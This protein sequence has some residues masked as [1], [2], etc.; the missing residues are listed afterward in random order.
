MDARPGNTVMSRYA[1]SVLV[2]VVAAASALALVLLAL[3]AGPASATAAGTK[4]DPT[5]LPISIPGSFQASNVG[6]EPSTAHDLVSFH[7]KFW[8]FT[9]AQSEQLS[10]CTLATAQGYDD[11]TLEVWSG[12]GAAVEVS[13]NDD[14]FQLYGSPLIE[15]S[16]LTFDTT[17]GTRYVVG[18]GGYQ[19]H[20]G[21]AKLVFAQGSGTNAC[22]PTPSITGKIY[23]ANHSELSAEDASAIVVT[24]QKDSDGSPS[25]I[26][27]NGDGTYTLRGLATGTYSLSFESPTLDGTLENIDVVDG[28]LTSGND[29]EVAP[30]GSISGTIHLPAGDD[31]SQAALNVWAAGNGEFHSGVLT[32]GVGGVAQYTISGLSASTFTV[33]VADDNHIYAQT[34]LPNVVV[35][36][37]QA[38][39]N[40]DITLVAGGSIT[41]TI[42][43]P[44]LES[45]FA[46]TD[47]YVEAVSGDNYYD[48]VLADPIGNQQAYSIGGLPAGTYTVRFRDDN[49]QYAG[50]TLSDITVT[51]G[52]ED[53]NHDVT[54][55][56][57]GSIT[58]TI[59]PPEGSSFGT[60]NV[61][62][63]ARND[64]SLIAGSFDPDTGNFSIV[65]L[66]SGTYSLQIVDNNRTFAPFTQTGV[67]VVAGQATGPISIT[68]QAAGT[69]AIHGNITLPDGQAVDAV[70]LVVDAEDENGHAFTAAVAPS[71]TNTT[72]YTVSGLSTSNFTVRLHDDTDT[73]TAETATSVAVTDGAMTSGID[74]SPTLTPQIPA[75]VG[76]P[77]G[78]AGNSGATLNWVAPASIGAPLTDYV[79]QYR[80]SVGGTVSTFEDGTSADT[81]AAVTGLQDGIGYKFRVAGINGAGRGAFSPW[82]ATVTPVVP[83]VTPTPGVTPP[84]PTP[85]AVSGSVAKSAKAKKKGKVKLPTSTNAGSQLAWVT[86]TPKVCKI[87]SGNVQLTGKK[88]SCKVIGTAAADPTHLAL[89]QTYT[90][91]VK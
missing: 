70:E 80:L 71:S 63:A 53:A 52:N 66:E 39:E 5:P 68:L 84:A 57:R 12:P 16:G 59:T 7:T 72:T 20:S 14:A 48:A 9:A 24:A 89:L 42:S 33:H 26:N 60:A 74:F 37:G 15:N 10:V 61:S 6:G 18:L 3:V 34:S 64:E 88:G 21:T 8:E 62:V 31:I 41:G 49:G 75:R 38:V 32:P 54:L 82:S 73:V 47:I 44:S 4:A 67:E 85:Q 91:K 13:T 90:I 55:T 36:A 28:E 22:Q 23:G 77:T 58:G 11:T 51:E 35:A 17:V 1:R 83:A 69:G 43:L 56:N 40:Q 50:A 25:T 46:G 78:T 79:V 19:S 45:S 27:A 29:V 65:G 76:A 81:N 30:R 2:P 87:K 86:K